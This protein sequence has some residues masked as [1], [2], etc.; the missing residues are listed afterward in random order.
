MT[1]ALRSE[2]ERCV[3]HRHTLPY[4]VLTQAGEGRWR[5]RRQVV[6]VQFRTC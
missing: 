6:L 4:L 2:E 5:K 3:F 1:E